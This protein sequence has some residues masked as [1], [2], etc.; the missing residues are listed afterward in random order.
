VPAGRVSATAAVAAVVV[1]L[2]VDVA[3]SDDDHRGVGANGLRRRRLFPVESLNHADTLAALLGRSL[4]DLLEA[5]LGNSVCG[6]QAPRGQHHRSRDQAESS[7]SGSYRRL[8]GDISQHRTC[9]AAPRPV[10]AENGVSTR[11]H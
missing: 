6:A 8:H 1:M 3:S 9:Q 11:N 2:A 10:G 5:P 7:E 4:G